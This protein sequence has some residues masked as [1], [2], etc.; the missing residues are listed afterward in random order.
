MC[1]PESLGGTGLGH[2]AYY[3]AWEAM[4]KHCGPH[5]WLMLYALALGVRAEQTARKTHTEARQTVLP[6]LM[7]WACLD[8]FWFV[9]TK[10]GF[11][12]INDQDLCESRW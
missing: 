9:G 7:A 8:V 6:E 2:L 4:F 3:V 5:N 12:R 1:V 11:R 10:R